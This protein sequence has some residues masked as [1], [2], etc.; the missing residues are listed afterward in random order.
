MWERALREALP[1]MRELLPPGSRVLEVGYGD[2]LLTCYLCQELG[3]RVI[4]LEVSPEAQ[5]L[6]EEQARQSGLSDYLDLRC[7][8]AAEVFRHRG[9]Y[10]GVFIKTVL[11]NSPNL[12]V[13]ARWLDWILSVLKPGGVFINFATGR[14]NALTQL[15]RRLRRRAYTDL[16]LYTSQVE[17]LYEARFE[18]IERR[19]Y[20]GLSQF[21]A[22]VPALY[23]PAS[24]L[25]E[26]RRSRHADNSFIMSVIA[27][28][29]VELKTSWRGN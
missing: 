21:L 14:A 1:A 10:D 22:S 9:Q 4:G 20:G 6:A 5:Q 17:A 11:Y 12:G 27:R 24:R 23:F 28:R 2:G 3:W 8:D 16:C 25:E 29:P 13:Y 15:Y 18:I 7:G 19:Y 26:A